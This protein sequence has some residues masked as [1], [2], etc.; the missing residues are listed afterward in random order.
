M[1]M[2]LCTPT[3]G[4]TAVGCGRLRRY[5]PGS[6][7]SVLG[8]TAAIEGHAIVKPKPRTWPGKSYT[9]CNVDALRDR[10]AVLCA[11]ADHL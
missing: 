9:C 7:L 5:P 4:A 11:A 2:R 8:S 1:S 10:H 3:P 6:A